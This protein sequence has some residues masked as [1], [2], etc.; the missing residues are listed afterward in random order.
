MKWLSIV[1]PAGLIAVSIVAGL[2]FADEPA[3]E[4][5]SAQVTAIGP[6]G[7]EYLDPDDDPR[8]QNRQ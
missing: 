3:G 8:K 5:A 1:L 7:L 4:Q 2:S 6:L